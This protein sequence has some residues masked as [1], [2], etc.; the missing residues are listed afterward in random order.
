MKFSEETFFDAE[1]LE[2]ATQL[3]LEQ[4]SVVMYD[5]V[6]RVLQENMA[7]VK[8]DKTTFTDTTKQEIAEQICIQIIQGFPEFGDSMLA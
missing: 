6:E 2:E 5:Y 3:Y 4:G 8:L 1:S 7:Q